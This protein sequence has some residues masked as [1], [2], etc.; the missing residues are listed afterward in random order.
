MRLIERAALFDEPEVSALH[1]KE[2]LA[3]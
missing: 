1:W 3:A 2:V